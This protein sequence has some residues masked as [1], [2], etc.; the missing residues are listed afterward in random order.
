[1]PKE[2]VPTDDGEKGHSDV[3][4]DIVDGYIVEV[5]ANVAYL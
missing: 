3:D 5:V 4:E 1:M 2:E